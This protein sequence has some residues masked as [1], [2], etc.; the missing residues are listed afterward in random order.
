MEKQRKEDSILSLLLP[1]DNDK[2]LKTEGVGRTE[3][4]RKTE[5]EGSKANSHESRALV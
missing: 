4:N 3:R 1:T 2:D 5:D